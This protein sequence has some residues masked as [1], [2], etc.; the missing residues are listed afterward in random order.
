M[1]EAVPP[2]E[3]RS[4]ATRSSACARR[5]SGWPAG[6][7]CGSRLRRAAIVFLL[8]LGCGLSAASLIAIWTRA[9]RAEHRP[10]RRR[11][12]RRSP[13][14]RPCRR[15]WPTSSTRRS[16]ARSTSTRSPATSCP[17]APTCWRRRS[18]PAPTARSASSSTASSRPTASPSCGTR[19]TGACTTRVVGAAHHREVR[20]AHARGRHRLPRPQRRRRPDQAA[21]CATRGFN[22]IADAIPPSVDG[23]IPLLTS[24]G[25][26]SAREGINLLKGLSVCSRCWR[27][28]ASPATCSCRRPRR[29]GWLRVALGLAVTGLLLLAAVGIGALGLPRRDRPERAAA[30]GGGGHLRRADRA[31]AHRAADRGHRRGRARAAQP[32]RRQAGCGR[33]RRPAARGCAPP[34]RACAPTRAPTWLAA[35]P[36]PRPSG[37]SCCW[38]GS[39]S[40]RGTTRP[41]AWS[42]STPR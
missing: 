10:L 33:A 13:R 41:R 34:G 18:R 1:S 27:C 42:S 23:S 35:Q 15:R 37:R 25:F 24:D 26:C 28:C 21:R 32:A 3:A 17:T 14:A 39:C 29:R 30:R 5:T 36:R 20:T 11:R 7:R 38:A 19:P 9:T 16:R 40:S 8:V 4:C 12:W 2:D 22:R 6:R 31:P